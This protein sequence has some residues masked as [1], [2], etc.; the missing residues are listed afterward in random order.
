MSFEDEK[1]DAAILEYTDT[2]QL[3][4]LGKLMDDIYLRKQ[5]SSNKKNWERRIIGEVLEVI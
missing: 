2:N 5:N 4:A 3:F 1:E